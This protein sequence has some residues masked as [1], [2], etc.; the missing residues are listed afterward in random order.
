MCV[1]TV[2]LTLAIGCGPIPQRLLNNLQ[3]GYPDEGP[4]VWQPRSLIIIL[5]G[6]LQVVAQ[7]HGLQVPAMVNSRIVKGLELYLQ[8]KRAGKACGLLI[9]GGVTHHSEPAEAQ[10][11]A[12]VFEKLGVD[13]AD[14]T[15]E[16][17]SLNTWQNAQ[18]SAAW[19]QAHPQD[20]IVLVTSGVHVRRSLLY[21]A[22]F[23]VRVQ[24]VRADYINAPPQLIPQ[25]AYL[26]LT[27]I[28]LHE[29]AGLVRYRVYNL[30]GWNV[31][32]KRP[33]A[34]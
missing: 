30:L 13:R 24:G 2:L 20:Q 1:L 8:C 16:S 23:G 32:A 9:S 25:A 10:V 17:K 19:L 21:F 26:F 18:F 14:L 6:G 34:L 4:Q 27:D 29:Y 33:G 5:G 11:Y 3:V 15:L 28:A 7:T 22:H 12:A 31:E